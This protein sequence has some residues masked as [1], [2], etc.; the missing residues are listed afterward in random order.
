MRLARRPCAKDTENTRAFEELRDYRPVLDRELD[1]LSSCLSYVRTL[2]RHK[3]IPTSL[4][5]RK[6]ERMANMPGPETESEVSS[7]TC[8]ILALH[9]T[10]TP[11]VE[12]HHSF[13]ISTNKCNMPLIPQFISLNVSK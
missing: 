10:T 13:R 9:V 5:W 2:K 1:R 4:L 11:K 6:S 8:C 3:R 7:A 12:Q